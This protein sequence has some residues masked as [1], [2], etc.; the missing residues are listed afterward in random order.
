[1]SASGVPTQV[2]QADPLEGSDVGRLE[3]H[4]GSLAGIEGLLPTGRAQ[5]P[6]ITRSEARESGLGTREVVADQPAEFEEIGVDP[7]TH[8]VGPEVVGPG[9][10]ASIAEEARQWLAAARLELTTENVLGHAAHL[11]TIKSAE[12]IADTRTVLRTLVLLVRG[13]LPALLVATLM[14]LAVFYVAL[15][16][17]SMIWAIALSVTYAYGVAIYQYARWRRLSGMLLVAVFMASLRVLAA[18]ASGHVV[19]FFAVPVLETAGFGLMFAATMFTSEPLVVRL[20]RDLIPHAADDFAQR[21][22]LIR[23][24]SLVWTVTYLASCTTSIVLLST[25]PLPVFLGA[26]TLTGWFWTGS[27]MVLTVS[28][29]RRRAAGLLDETR[30]RPAPLPVAIDG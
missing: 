3:Y 2:I 15:A 20:A 13:A 23:T 10:A 17:G 7:R 21:G 25:V 19:M 14:P 5:A 16:A 1:M 26:H 30:L 9:V 29:C 24:L 12:A 28:L 27:G 22:S 8:H 11:S 18:V 6:L 4:L